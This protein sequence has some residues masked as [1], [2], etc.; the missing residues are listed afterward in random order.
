MFKILV[1][2][3]ALTFATLAVLLFP[4]QLLIVVLAIITALAIFLYLK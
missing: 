1:V 3:M 2:V 4:P